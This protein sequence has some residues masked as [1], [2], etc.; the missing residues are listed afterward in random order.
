MLSENRQRLNESVSRSFHIRREAPLHLRK[1]HDFLS[2]HEIKS[3]SQLN[4]R[5]IFARIV[6]EWS[7]IAVTIYFC[8]LYWSVPS[9]FVAI[10]VIGSRQHCL[11][12]LLH[13]GAHGRIHTNKLINRWVSEVFLAFPF[14]VTHHGFAREHLTHHRL[15]G[16]ANDPEF[17][18]KEHLHEYVFPKTTV[19]LISSFVKHISGMLTFREYSLI[20][21]TAQYSWR[22]PKAV[23]VARAIFYSVLATTLWWFDLVWVY[24][25]FWVLPMLTYL[26]FALYFRLVA[27]HFGLPEEAEGFETR[28]VLANRIERFLFAPVSINYHTEHHLYP[29]VPYYNLASLHRR[30]MRSSFANKVHLTKGYTTQLIAEL[31]GRTRKL[32]QAT[33]ARDVAGTP[34]YIEYSRSRESRLPVHS[35]TPPRK[36]NRHS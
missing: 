20:M 9:I 22:V 10:I 14:F 7:L 5:R 24:L 27:E 33:T 18:M 34:A 15:L 17:L 31:L 8:D 25:T 28:T 30:L 16:D 23:N 13:E 21:V 29:S 6:A 19:G 2:P 35:R 36:P 3:L 32:D 1:E 12:M 11:L 4:P 26:V